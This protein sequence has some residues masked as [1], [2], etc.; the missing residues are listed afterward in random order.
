[1]SRQGVWGRGFQTE[2]GA[3][4]ATGEAGEGEGGG[5]G[6]WTWR[7][8]RAVTGNWGSLVSEEETQGDREG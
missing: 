4:G 7:D 5:T 3:P 1:M 6:S 2:G 8:W